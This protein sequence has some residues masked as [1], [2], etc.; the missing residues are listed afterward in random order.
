MHQVCRVI[1]SYTTSSSDPIVVRTGEALAVS[2]RVYH[3][4][5]NPEW[6]WVWCSDPRRRSG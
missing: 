2:D 5:D 1:A 4:D 3:W 6:V